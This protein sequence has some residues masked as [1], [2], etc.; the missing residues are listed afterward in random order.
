MAKDVH[1]DT[2]RRALE[3]DGWNITEDPLP[4]K[5]DGQTVYAD[6]GAEAPIE[7]ERN[8]LIEAERDGRKIA[9]EVKSFL[10]ASPPA[11]ETY[12][13]MGRYA[14]YSKLMK[15]QRAGTPL[16]LAVPAGVY[17][18][19]WSTLDGQRM[20]QRLQIRLIVY[21]PTTERITEWLEQM[22]V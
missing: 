21:E 20:T 7:A 14:F 18:T 16:Y 4:L 3:A 13:A 22:T 12:E 11:T 19:D 2:V 17:R 15:S 5:P 8:A 9:V 10:A 1:H 6:L